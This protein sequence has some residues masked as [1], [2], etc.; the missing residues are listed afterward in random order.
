MCNLTN[1]AFTDE[2]KARDFLE[3]SRW[4]DGAVC[5]HCNQR[6]NV[7]PLPPEAM[8]SKPSKKNPQP[9]PTKGWYHCSACRGKFTVAVGT[10]YERSH[11]PLHKWLLATHLITSSK[12]GI[13]AHQ[14]HR[15][16]GVT[17]KS[18]WFM[19]HR[20]REGMKET[21]VT[22][23]DMGGQNE[24]VEVDET[25][26]GGKAKN[27]KRGKPEPQKQAVVSLVEREGRVR[28]FHVPAVTASNL[29][30]ILTAHINAKSVLMTDE[31]TVYRAKG[32]RKGFANH[33]SVNH[34]QDE[35]VRL[36]GYV[37]TNS[38]EGYFSIL[39]R[40]ITGVFH[41]VSEQHLGRYLVEFDFRYN[42]R[43]ALGVDDQSRFEK[44]VKGIEGKRL[45]YR[46]TDEARA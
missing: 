10:L 42:N 21:G 44:A 25:Y 31:S 24:A 2:D 33:L 7:K 1:P 40:G 9:K 27:A 17:Y 5:P 43:I 15:M 6:E 41:H 13:S 28:S 20:I 19:A 11:I 32:I 23:G 12:K 3:S 4:P 37:H 16:L 39:K 22:G 14:L 18:A 30:P 8:M 46:R 35:Y 45:T 26:V 36:G 38:V 29:R 34:S